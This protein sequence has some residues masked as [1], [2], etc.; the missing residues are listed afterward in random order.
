MSRLLAAIAVLAIVSLGADLAYS[1]ASTPRDGKC[2]VGE[3]ANARRGL[4][5]D[6][7]TCRHRAG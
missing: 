2:G 4:A 1:R 5:R 6:T 7:P 3:P